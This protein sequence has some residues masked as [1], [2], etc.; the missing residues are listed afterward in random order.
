MKRKTLETGVDTHTPSRNRRSRRGVEKD[1]ERDRGT[2][3]VG[4]MG[5]LATA[6]EALDDKG[7][8]HVFS[9]SSV[10]QPMSL[11]SC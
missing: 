7:E 8:G 1:G 5:I 2:K 9:L 3:E 4:K 10:C 6:F 11:A